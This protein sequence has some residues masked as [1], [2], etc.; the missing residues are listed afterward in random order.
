LF[1]LEVSL[2]GVPKISPALKKRA[3]HIKP[4]LMDGGWYDNGGQIVLLSQTDGRCIGLHNQR[5]EREPRPQTYFDLIRGKAELDDSYYDA[6][7]YP[8]LK[9]FSRKLANHVAAT[10]LN[11]FV[12]NFIK[13]CWALRTGPVIAAGVTDRVWSV[14]DLVALRE[15]YEQRTAE[16]QVA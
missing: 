2:P 13:I 15:G 10:A 9:W 8:S 12:Y 3:M 11:Y 6:A 4:L 5:C 14:V 1:F 16:R 7:L